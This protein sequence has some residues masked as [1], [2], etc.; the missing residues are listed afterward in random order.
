MPVYVYESLR[1]G[2]QFELV[3]SMKDAALKTHPQTGEPIKRVITAPNLGGRYSERAAK[4]SVTSEN[5]A[6][7][8]FTK[9]VKNRS[10]GQ[11]EYAGGVRP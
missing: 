2:E 3:H 10:T 4:A 7:N 9:L 1:T 5:L 11:Y 6:K 8:G